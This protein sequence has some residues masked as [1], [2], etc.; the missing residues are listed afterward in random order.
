M[1]LWIPAVLIAMLLAG[2]DRWNGG[3]WAIGLLLAGSVALV[4]A[5]WGPGQAPGKGLLSF[6]LLTAFLPVMV[7]IYGVMRLLLWMLSGLSGGLGGGDGR[8]RLARMAERLT[9]GSDA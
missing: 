5:D 3:W 2:F 4:A 7:G 6:V 9:P 8:K 1:D